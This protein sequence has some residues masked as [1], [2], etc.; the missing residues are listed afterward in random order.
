M[1]QLYFVCVSGCCFLFDLV[2]LVLFFFFKQKRPEFNFLNA[3][4]YF[5]KFIS[6]FMQFRLHIHRLQ[7]CLY[8]CLLQQVHKRQT[9]E[10]EI[11]LLSHSRSVCLQ[12]CTK[13]VVV[14]VLYFA[15]RHRANC[16]QFIVSCKTHTFSS[17]APCC[18][19]R[20]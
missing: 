10:Q 2:L 14:H 17:N 7:N 9:A 16:M 18:I 4:T 1:A 12:I 3:R 13:Q 5:F 8:V 15:K 6:K 11:M 19:I 20:E